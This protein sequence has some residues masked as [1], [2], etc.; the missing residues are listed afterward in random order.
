MNNFFQSE[1]AHIL[2]NS[3]CD[4]QI[5]TIEKIVIHIII[6]TFNDLKFLIKNYNFSI[7]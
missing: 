2:F 4:D 3:E 6:L 1:L 7:L 5:F